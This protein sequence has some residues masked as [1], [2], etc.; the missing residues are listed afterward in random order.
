[1]PAQP[2]AQRAIT[3]FLQ[4]QRRPFR[5]LLAHCQ[6]SLRGTELVV[7]CPD[8]HARHALW[9]RRHKI[10]AS[11]PNLGVTAIRFRQSPQRPH[12]A[13]SPEPDSD[14]RAAES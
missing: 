4:R 6:L 2:F 3:L 11:A 7:T 13:G 1:M 10:A 12:L 5:N 9:L 8:V 14:E